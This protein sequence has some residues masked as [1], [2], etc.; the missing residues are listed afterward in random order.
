MCRNTSGKISVK[1]NL[2][3]GEDA[4][5]KLKDISANKLILTNILWLNCELIGVIFQKFI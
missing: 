3:L 1:K 4:G 2:R 5:R